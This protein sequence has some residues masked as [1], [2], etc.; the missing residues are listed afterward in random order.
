M[1]KYSV[2]KLTNVVNN[3]NYIGQTS[4]V[5]R[6]MAEHRRKNDNVIDKA[7]DKY[8]WN[9]FTVEV[10]KEN[11]SKVE[12]DFWEIYLINEVYNS[13]KGKGYNCSIGGDVNP[14]LN[15]HHDKETREK[16]SKKVRGKNSPWY[17]KKLTKEHKQKI[18]KENS[19]KNHHCYGKSLPESTRKK[20]SKAKIGKNNPMYG[21]ERTEEAKNNISLAYKE[22]IEERKEAQSKYSKGKYLEIKEE[23]EQRDVTQ[24][25]LSKEYNLSVT[26]ISRVVNGK[27]WTTS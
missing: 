11:L 21:K 1:G 26:T 10:L 6:R 20:M 18:R 22:N 5:K 17:G 25:Q 8:G 12:A 24:T 23:Y 15:K 4:N 27:H 7:I 2:Y 9:N 14:M 13:Y 19:G 16:I 3:K